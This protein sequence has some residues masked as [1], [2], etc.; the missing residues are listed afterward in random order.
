MTNMNVVGFYNLF[1]YSAN[2]GML[3]QSAG[4]SGLIQQTPISNCPFQNLLGSLGAALL[5]ISCQLAG[6]WNID[7]KRSNL[8]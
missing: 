1:Q 6:S 8:F 4:L 7:L 3:R 5:Y 2:S